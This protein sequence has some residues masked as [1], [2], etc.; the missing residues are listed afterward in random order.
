MWVISNNGRSW[1]PCIFIFIHHHF[2][3]FWTFCKVKQKKKPRDYSP[4]DCMRLISF[5]VVV[6]GLGFFVVFLFACL[7]VYFLSDFSLGQTSLLLDISNRSPSGQQVVSIGPGHGLSSAA[8]ISLEVRADI[9]HIQRNQVKDTR[10][11]DMKASIQFTE[12]LHSHV[13]GGHR[14]F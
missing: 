1:C 3:V 4:E 13:S 14:F 6:E 5:K 8:S 2:I 9:L 7:F 11:V 12:I 10:I